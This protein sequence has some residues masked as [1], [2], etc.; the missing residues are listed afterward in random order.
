M[1]EEEFSLLL[2]QSEP[3]A[4]TVC[5]QSL[6]EALVGST[7]R[8]SPVPLESIKTKSATRRGISLSVSVLALTVVFT[9]ILFTSETDAE[10]ML[11]FEQA[12]QEIEELNYQLASL[13]NSRQPSASFVSASEIRASES[14]WMLMQSQEN[15]QRQLAETIVS[16]YSNTP[17]AGRCRSTHP[18]LFSKDQ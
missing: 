18:G 7:G 9:A 12:E 13:S 3:V 11:N 2:K 15:N 14:L 17:A 6:C 5:S 1:N 8:R 10:L 16:L 4:P